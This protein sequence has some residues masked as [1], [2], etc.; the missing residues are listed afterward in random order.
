MRDLV[1][2]LGIEPRLS[3]LGAWSL[4]HWTT[5]EVAPYFFFLM[6]IVPNKHRRLLMILIKL[7]KL[8]F[9]SPP[10]VMLLS[11]LDLSSLIRDQT[12]CPPTLGA[13][14]LN[15][16]TSREVLR[17]PYLINPRGE[18]S[19][20]GADHPT[21]DMQLQVLLADAVVSQWKALSM[22]R[23]HQA[24]RTSGGCLPNSLFLFPLRSLCSLSTSMNTVNVLEHYPV[25]FDAVLR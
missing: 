14:S 9:P 6:N 16:W 4:S 17:T 1:P 8:L 13:W 11:M 22:S 12:C 15:H 25:F 5:I 10:P 19:L 18:S 21:L 2:W 7:L 24:G 23:W 20:I 3:A